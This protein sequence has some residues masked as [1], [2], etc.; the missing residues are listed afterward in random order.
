MAYDKIPD[1]Y[2]HLMTLQEYFESCRMG[3]FTDYDGFCYPVK[4]GL[5]DE[6]EQ[7]SPSELVFMPTD[8]THIVWYNK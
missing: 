8:M 6:S 5:V 1:E 2:A 4:D 7:Y 3:L